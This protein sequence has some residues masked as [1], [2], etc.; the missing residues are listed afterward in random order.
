MKNHFYP[1]S[2]QKAKEKEFLELEQETMSVLQ[3][4][5]KFIEV[6]G[7]P[8]TY[9]AKETLRMNRFES[10]LDHKLKVSRYVCTYSSYQEMYNVAIN[11]EQA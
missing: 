11:V 1:M 4:A 3:Y 2:L 10:R 8:P 5:S 6:S 7:Y 9:V